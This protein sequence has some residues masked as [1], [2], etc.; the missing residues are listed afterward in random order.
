MERMEDAAIVG[1]YFKRDEKAVSATMESYNDRLFRFAKRFLSDDRDAEECVNDAYARAW[2]TIPPVRPDNLFAYLAALCRN[3][4]L[5]VIKRDSAQK[6]SAQLVE[7][8]HEMS[9]CIPD[10]NSISDD[11]SEELSD[12]INEYL[13]TLP[14]EKRAVFMGRYWYNESISDIAKKTGFSQSKVKTMLFRM[15]EDL[16]KHIAGKDGSL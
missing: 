2:K 4:A 1:L 9:E 16:R 14:R 5:D 6:R 8:T 15:R 7:L 10:Q 12:Y 3:A 11:R 13:G